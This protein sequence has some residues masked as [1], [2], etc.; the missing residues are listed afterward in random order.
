[1]DNDA[2]V[3][4]EVSQFVRLDFV[5][6]DLG[7]VDVALSGTV[8]PGAFH[9]SLLADKIGGL[10]GVGFMGARKMAERSRRSQ[11]RAQASAASKRQ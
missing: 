4:T 9:D 3:V 1:V 8:A 7:V 2:F 5:F 11:P 6:L 10:N